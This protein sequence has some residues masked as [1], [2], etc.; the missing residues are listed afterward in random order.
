MELDKLELALRPRSH[1]EAIDLGFAMG[2]RWFLP[3]AALWLMSALPLTLLAVVLLHENLLL[4]TLLIWWCKPLYEPALV[5]WLSRAVFGERLPLREIRRHWWQLVRPQ[6]LANLSWRRLSGNRSFFMPV[7]LLEGLTGKARKQRVRVLGRRQQAGSWLTI[8]GLHF[9]VVLELGFLLTIYFLIPQELR[10]FEGGAFFFSPGSIDQW[11]Q[12][13][14]WLFAAAIIA[15][16]YV[17][18]GFALYLNRRSELEGWDL[19]INFRRTVENHRSERRNRR[20]PLAALLCLGVSLYGLMPADARA[21]PA[22][23]PEQSRQTIEQVLQDP[24]FG[25][26]QERSAWRYV[27][28]PEK[29]DSSGNLPTFFRV[30]GKMLQGFMRGIATFGEMILW[31]L[32]AFVVAYLLY[33]FS[34]NAS[35]LGSGDSL[36]RRRRKAP[37]PGELFGLDVRPESLPG[38]IPESALELARK[39]DMRGALSLLYRGALARLVTEHQLEIPQSATEEECLGVV[40]HHAARD[41][42]DYFRELTA[43]WLTTAY[44]HIT[45]D[46]RRIEQLCHNWRQVYGHVE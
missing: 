12:L 35:W 15:P 32:A 7:A 45:P 29:D 6:L 17:A 34:K 42:A 13:F 18:G 39:G 1:W 4:L 22:P 25:R 37:H 43:T 46:A 16:F 31:G 20:A 41:E 40:R 30:L 44:A 8:V 14:C 33:H 10:W 26:L 28:K 19:E 3:L 27:G 9:E 5:F 38:N 23:G 24:R 11:L 36:R 2:R 21:A